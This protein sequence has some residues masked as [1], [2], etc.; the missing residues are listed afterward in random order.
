MLLDYLYLLVRF[1]FRVCSGFS[2]S[3]SVLSFLFSSLIEGLCFIER[4]VL[5]LRLGPPARYN[6]SSG[7]L[8]FDLSKI[9]AWEL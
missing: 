9:K 7:F 4:R 2:T 6:R 1:W 3:W 5:R 8:A